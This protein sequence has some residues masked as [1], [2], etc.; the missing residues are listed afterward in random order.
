MPT[1]DP[2]VELVIHDLT[3]YEASDQL[4]ETWDFSA[5]TSPDTAS[6]KPASLLGMLRFSHFDLPWNLEAGQASNPG[7]DPGGGATSGCIYAAY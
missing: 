3:H 4:D 5:G 6:G 7:G 1:S 2:I